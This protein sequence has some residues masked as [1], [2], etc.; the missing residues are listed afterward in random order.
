MVEAG[1]PEGPA[2]IPERVAEIAGGAA[3]EPVWRNELGG[4]T[5]RIRRAGSTRY[6]KWQRHR[7]LGA[8]HRG[9]V[10]LAIEAEKLVWAGRF[11]Q[12]PSVLDQGEDED[13]AWLVIEGIE[14]TS[15]FD[16]RW[17]EAPE[18]AV[19]AIATG[20]RRLHEALPVRECPYAGARLGP[21]ASGTPEPERLV[22]CHGDPCVPNT[23]IDG[24]GGFAGHVDLAR[25]G[26]A[27]RWADLAIATYSISWEVNFGRSYDEL[28]FEAYGVEPDED[29]LRFYRNLWDSS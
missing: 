27:D 7:G 12:V 22:V 23:L 21:N 20:L 24:V 25:L 13:D 6:V 29:R 14:A 16:P 2:D 3:V 11:A 18:T 9:H 5:F 8:E 10:D 4:I 17:R 28:F 26:V 19:R 1:R 15:A